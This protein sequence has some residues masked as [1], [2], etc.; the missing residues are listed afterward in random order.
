MRIKGDVGMNEYLSVQEY[1]DLKGISTRSV[2]KAI[3]KGKLQ[4]K[5][6]PHPKRKDQVAYMVF[7]GEPIGEPNG[8][9]QSSSIGMANFS[10]GE[11]LP[12]NGEPVEIMANHS[13]APLNANNTPTATPSACKPDKQPKSVV[14]ASLPTALSAPPI[15]A[16]LRETPE[17]TP[18]QK[19]TEA[20]LFAQLM[21]SIHQRINESENKTTAWQA[22]AQEYNARSLAPD[23]YRL[24]GKRSERALRHWYQ[25]WNDSD[26]DMFTLIHHNTAHTRGRMVTE[27]EQSYLLKFLLSDKKL[28]V[29]SVI[30]DLKANAE[31]GLIE[32]PSSAPTLKRWVNDWTTAHPAEWGQA[33]KGS[34]WVKD[35]VVKSI[36]R[37][38]SMLKVGDVLVIDGHTMSFDTIN[39]VTGKPARLTLILLF[40]WASRYP[41]GA[42]LAMSESS[43]HVLTAVRN[44][45][46]HIGFLPR[47][48]LFDNGKAFRSKL[49]HAKWE[50]HDL[51]IEFA[52]IFPRLGIEAEFAEAYNAR[53][54]TIERF[55][56]T[57][58]EQFERFQ[59]T[60]RGRNIDDKPA[61]LSRNEK[62][63]QKMFAGKPLTH[64]EALDLTYYYFRHIYGMRPH[65]GIANHKPFEVFA[66]AQVDQSRIIQPERLN[67]LML[68][69]ERKHLRS[70]GIW[71]NNC[72]YYDDELINHIGQQ[73]IIRYDYS[74]LRW[75]LVYDLQNRPICQAAMRESRHG[76]IYLERD[77]PIA[78]QELYAEMKHNKRLQTQIRKNTEQLIK[79]HTKVIDA[80]LAKHQ[81]IKDGLMAEIKESNPTFRQPPMITAPTPKTN[82]NDEI[83]RLEKIALSSE[84]EAPASAPQPSNLPTFQ[85]KI[86]TL[87]SEPEAP[88]S[89][90]NPKI[91]TLSDLLDDSAPLAETVSFQELQKIIGIKR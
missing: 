67:F 41:V 42:A 66:A 71:L 17:F 62:W 10:N 49:F 77:N 29:A 24:K 33:R 50:N 72:R 6:V 14:K 87:S 18:Y 27:K 76:F 78:H 73:V 90:P 35:N 21:E 54:K 34:K 8:E 13:G 75:I 48:I 38:T 61:N 68:T 7:Y 45:I 63:A 36:W 85:P 43:Q 81:H 12:N 84:P 32:S 47:Y 37:D 20:Q 46:L 58:Q 69:A 2:Q 26:N 1:A 65:S 25:K 88:A 51:A 16:N 23:L 28:S 55:F 86:I 57:L 4:T 22:L 44:A 15:C 11:L 19:M 53:T 70:E 59:D 82:P 31:L 3:A 40:D 80:E 5:E 91:I 56:R 9:P 60:F 64:E 52:G 79:H 39:P 74:D 30:N 83:Q 89:A